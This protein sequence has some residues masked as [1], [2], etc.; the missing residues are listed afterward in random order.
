MRRG[1]RPVATRSGLMRARRHRD[2][3]AR[4]VGLLRRK[5]EAL[6][7][8]LFHLARPAIDARAQIRERA[9]LAYDALLEATAVRGRNE[10]E[11]LGWPLREP[12]VEVRA[13]R[14]WG[15]P[16]AE[17]VRK[18]PLVRT[19]AARGSA[20]GSAGPA[21][22]EAARRF[23]LLADLLLEAAPQEIL[24]RRLGD[25]LVRTSRQVNVLEQRVAPE[26][27]WRIAAIRQ[28]LQD[29]EREEHVRLRHLRRR[30]GSS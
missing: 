7:A 26:A 16:V 17:L 25:A 14:V 15:L 1:G 30:R 22:A 28:A 13:A 12:L 5:R 9:Q 23:E 18:P 10:L 2:R 27:E 6:V 11:A 20:P 3:V 8:E 24:I 29:R 19:V 21:A 4:G